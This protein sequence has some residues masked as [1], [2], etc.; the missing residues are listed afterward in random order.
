MYSAAGRGS[1][2][3]LPGAGPPPCIDLVASG[4]IPPQMKT[5]PLGR[6]CV[7]ADGRL[8]LAPR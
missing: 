4:T 5:V 8:T 6:H 1:A 2:L 7:A 3:S